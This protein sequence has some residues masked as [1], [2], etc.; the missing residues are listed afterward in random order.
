MTQGHCESSLR[1]FGVCR[2][3]PSGRRHSDQATWFGL[4]SAC[5]R[6]LS[7]TTTIAIYYYYSARKMILI[8]H[9]TE[10]RRL[11]WPRHCRK[12]AHSSQG[13]KSQ[14]IYDKHNCPQ[15]DSIPGP[16]A[17]QSGMLPLDYCDQCDQHLLQIKIFSF[18]WIWFPLNLANDPSVTSHLKRG[19][20]YLVFFV[21]F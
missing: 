12:G 5:F 19:T 13:C 11:S 17:L 8:Y 10:G 21:L 6:Q 9:P 16:R 20:V 2:T 1:S 7:S 18:H 3:A 4:W 15:R 14:W